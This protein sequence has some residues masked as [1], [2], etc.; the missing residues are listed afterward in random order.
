MRLFGSRM[1]VAAQTNSAWDL[2][3]KPPVTARPSNPSVAI[4]GTLG[5]SSSHARRA[6]RSSVATHSSRWKAIAIAADSP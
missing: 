1:L 6:R 2:V 4:Q 5:D 3:R